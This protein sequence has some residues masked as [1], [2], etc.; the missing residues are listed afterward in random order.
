[1]KGSK[2]QMDGKVLKGSPA[3][4][5]QS[6]KVEEKLVVQQKGIENKAKTWQVAFFSFNNTAS[7]TNLAMMSFF[8][9]FTQNILGMAAVLVG[10]IATSMRI[11]DAI[12]DPIVGALID[13]TDG[14]FGKYRPYMVIGSV[15]M[16]ISMIFIFFCPQ[17]LPA[18]AALAYIIFFYGVYVLGYT[19]QTCVTKGGQT[20]LTSDPKQRPL[21][22]IFD[23]IA[24][25]LVNAGLGLFLTTILAPRF[26]GGILNP[27][28]WKIVVLIAVVLQTI[29]TILA[30]I[31]IKEKDQTKYFGLGDGKV[32]KLSLKEMIQ[33]LGENKGLRH[34]ML[35]ANTEKVGWMI[36]N[37]T[38]IYFYANV[39]SN[40]ALQGTMGMIA[41]IPTMLATIVGPMIARKKGMKKVYVIVNALSLVTLAGIL[42]MRPFGA[43]SVLLLLLL[44]LER[45][46]STVSV[47]LSNPMIADCTD[48][49]LYLSKRY[50]PG[51]I[52]SIFSFMDK[53]V[54]SLS[55]FVLGLALALAGYGDKV[56]VPN[57]QATGSLYTALI[58]C[59]FVIPMAC[60]AISL[61]SMRAYPLSGPKMEEV[62]A[63]N[64][65]A[66][67]NMKVDNND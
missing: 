54:S 59:M 4:L 28:V 45:A 65:L 19:C 64:A 17:N 47:Y 12:T 37:A 13:R 66:R 24:S 20:A 34:L 53:F 23:G 18:G 3:V 39:L 67:A 61:I 1:M 31:G 27:M 46:F 57:E 30:I 43:P 32:T 58:V 52:G 36:Y 6:S 15:L 35:S 41:M 60:H 42:A 7:N 22:S 40:S 26:D 62:Q 55:T 14:K 9:V 38:I 5:G 44:V 56:I 63:T 51:A 29:L 16:N 48:Y 11:F 33:V 50:I 2:K 21:F 49:E 10:A 25:S 8:M